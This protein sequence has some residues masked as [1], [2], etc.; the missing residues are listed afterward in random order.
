MNTYCPPFDTSRHS[1]KGTWSHSSCSVKINGLYFACD[2]WMCGLHDNVI[3]GALYNNYTII[4]SPASRLHTH[5]NIFSCLSRFC[6]VCNEWNTCTDLTHTHTST[7]SFPRT[8]HNL[9]S[10]LDLFWFV[11]TMQTGL[12]SKH[13]YRKEQLVLFRN[14]DSSLF[15][16]EI[17]SCLP[18]PHETD[19][20]KWFFP[21]IH[22]ISSE[23]LLW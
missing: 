7:P 11:I 14:N 8:A 4:I 21:L 20:H 19:G 5:A 12:S 17:K 22:G 15:G 6:I 23:Q 3:T 9:L 2:H 1:D 10:D 13:K 16:T 18:A